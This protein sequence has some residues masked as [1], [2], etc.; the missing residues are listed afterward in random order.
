[1]GLVD[2]RLVARSDAEL[3]VVC[4]AI[5]QALP[6]PPF[7]LDGHSS[8]EYAIA[9][10]GQLHC[11]VTKYW[12]DPRSQ[13]WF[14]K[15]PGNANYCVTLTCGQRLVAELLPKL[16]AALADVLDADLHDLGTRPSRMPAHHAP[17]SSDMDDNPPSSGW[18]LPFSWI[19]FV[20]VAAAVFFTLRSCAGT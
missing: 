15:V 19:L 18:S 7:D 8:W 6:T 16:R 13:W 11:N 2:H 20:G 12:D 1:M 3:A 10:S 9:A 4:R 5:E 14:D 17:Q